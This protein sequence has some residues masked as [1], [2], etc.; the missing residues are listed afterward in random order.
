MSPDPIR[1]SH[2]VVS[3]EYEPTDNPKRFSHLVASLEVLVPCS[4]QTGVYT[5]DRNRAAAVAIAASRDNF[6]KFPTDG[7]GL[8]LP[9]PGVTTVHGSVGSARN[10]SRVLDHQASTGSAIF[11]SECIHAGGLPMTKDPVNPTSCDETGSIG[12]FDEKGWRVCPAAEFGWTHGS[13]SP[14]WRDH[15]GVKRYFSSDVFYAEITPAQVNSAI[16]FD[17][18]Q[19]TGLAGTI[20][21]G[22]ETALAALFSSGNLA[23][24]EVG[25]YIFVPLQGVTSHGFLVVGWGPVLDTLAALNYNS[26]SQTRSGTHP[27]PYIADFCFG[28]TDGTPDGTGWLQDPRP[29][30]FYASAVLMGDSRLNGYPDSYRDRLQAR[31]FQPFANSD[32]TRSNWQSYRIPSTMDV[33]SSRVYCE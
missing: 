24:V 29:R 28:T 3:V 2:E 13:A 16:H 30:P 21:S 6:D 18:E 10:Y 33:P 12:M 15:F 14:N 19:G 23:T 5:Y 32:G 11:I 1:F 31:I 7:T 17:D 4:N 26:L 22:G 9:G 20:K 27:I 25:D 8:G